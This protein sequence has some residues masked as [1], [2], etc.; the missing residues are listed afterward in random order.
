MATGGVTEAG[1][2]RLLVALRRRVMSGR[3][4]CYGGGLW[5]A[6]GGVAEA[7]YGQPLV[8]LLLQLLSISI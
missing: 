2:G 8:A 1:Y 6:V 4:W 5:A 7:G 3:W